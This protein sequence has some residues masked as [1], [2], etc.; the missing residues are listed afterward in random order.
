MSM[1]N[2]VPTDKKGVYM[3]ICN[4]NIHKNKLLKI[5]SYLLVGVLIVTALLFVFSHL[6]NQN[7]VYV[8]DSTNYE[9]VLEIPTA[10]YTNILK[11][12][13]ENIDKYIGKKIRFSGF[14]HRLYD[15]SDNQFVLAREMFTSPISNN[16]AEV[17]VVGFLCEYNGVSS[18][19]DKTWVEVEGTIT[20]GFY[21]STTP[22]VNVTSI[23]QVNCPNDP[24]V[25]P[26]DGGYAGI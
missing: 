4:V 18:L 6:K 7:T 24:F 26:P 10:N 9:E 15:F 25:N 3:F 17:V 12:S 8:T 5:L 21:Q 16:Q 2:I 23:K 22:I 13:Y 1:V 11:D 20:K 14:V 19:K